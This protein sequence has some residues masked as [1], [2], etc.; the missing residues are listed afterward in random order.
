V[1]S[2]AVIHRVR[3]LAAPGCAVLAVE[4]SQPHCEEL[5]MQQTTPSSARAWAITILLALFMVINF[6][7][8]AVLGIVAVPLMNDLHLS[9]G[10]FGMIA[11]SFFFLFSI[12]AISFGFFANRIA[13]KTLLLWCSLVWA[14]AQFP[15][16]LT[17]SIPLLFF[18]RILLGAGEGPAYPLA[19][20]ACYKWFPNDRRNL[21]SA[22][23][24]QG[25]TCGI[26]ISG[27]VLSYVLVGHGWHAAFF[28]LGMAS[29]VWMVLWYLIG[30]EGTIG[31]TSSQTAGDTVRVPYW[32][33]LTDRTFI[34]N[35]TLYWTTYWVFSLI[36]TWVP[37]YLRTVMHYDATTTG[38]MFMFFTAFNIPMVLIGSWWSE[39]MLKRGIA[40]V[41]ARGWLACGFSLAGG[42]L[43]ML[44][45]Y[46]VQQPLLKT[47]LLAI[48]CNLPQITFVLS[49]AIVAE[50]APD[51]Q[52]SA[53]MSINSALATTGGLVAPAL[54]GYFIGH[55]STHSAGYDSGFILAGV[56]SV[57]ASVI[58]F[59]TINPEGSKRRVARCLSQSA[60]S[61]SYLRNTPISTA[62]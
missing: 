55:A 22:I 6:C 56:M 14:V 58:G 42:A 5:S 47:A 26:L 50:I 20:H 9:P 51:S 53:M 12:S 43:I 3:L 18:S 38:W 7:D 24:F 33:L 52:R 23:V 57:V 27:P 15:V 48:G 10:E 19:L 16:A 41:R 11:S 54:M 17:A 61:T 1:A 31:S 39:R 45:V 62:D 25:A 36:F 59:Y 13:S 49:S 44:A 37:S 8:K 32:T 30:A 35:M 34:G 46:G 40:S 21:P 29:L 28:A 2:A 4:R 60:E